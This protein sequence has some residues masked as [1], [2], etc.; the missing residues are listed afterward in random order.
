MCAVCCVGLCVGFWGLHY[1]FSLPVIT[2]V[3]HPSAKTD[4]F[5]P[6]IYLSVPPPLFSIPECFITASL[7]LRAARTETQPFVTLKMKQLRYTTKE[8]GMWRASPS[9]YT[10]FWIA[11][12]FHFFFICVQITIR[13]EQLLYVLIFVRWEGRLGFEC[14]T[15]CIL[16]LLK[17]MISLHHNGTVSELWDKLTNNFN[18]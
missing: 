10:S 4:L 6:D 13:Q 12:C 16:S 2:L 3:I 11:S 5:S 7:S 8:K 18:E 14:C 15:D 9:H 17:E 1:P